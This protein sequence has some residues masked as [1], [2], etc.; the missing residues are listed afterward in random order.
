M[1]E[2]KFHSSRDSVTDVKVPMYIFSRFNDLR[3]EPQSIFTEKDFINR[4]LIVTNN[5]FSEDAVKFA[6]CSG[7]SLLSWDL[8]KENTLR[9]L[10][11]T[12]RLFPIT[13]LTTITRKEKEQLLLQE[14]ILVE[15]LKDT[16]ESLE[17][18]GISSNRIKNILKEVMALCN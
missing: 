4:C 17:F 15:Q 13:C 8:P 2:C 14:I 11:D 10:I 18:I 9:N 3:T 7:L 6:Y 12:T 1:V 5:R 16:I